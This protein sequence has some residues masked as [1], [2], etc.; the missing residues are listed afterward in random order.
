MLTELK[1]QLPCD[2]E[3]PFLDIYPSEMNVSFP[4]KIV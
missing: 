3:T 4:P 2:S 1:I